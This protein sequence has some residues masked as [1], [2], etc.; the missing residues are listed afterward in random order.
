MTDPKATIAAGRLA[1]AQYLLF[2]TLEHFDSAVKD[3]PVP[4]TSHIVNNLE[5]SLI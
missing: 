2:G 3:K 1:G 4:Y 5:G